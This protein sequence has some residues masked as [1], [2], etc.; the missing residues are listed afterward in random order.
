MRARVILSPAT[1]F[2]GSSFQLDRWRMRASA[3]QGAAGVRLIGILGWEAGH[4]DI[5][6]QFE[7]IAGNIANPNTF[8]FPVIYKQ[9]KGAYY[10]TV[11]VQP[12]V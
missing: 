1:W 6:S 3:K 10:Q 11:V 5:L 9:V 12:N 4:K 8:D 2:K 7:Q